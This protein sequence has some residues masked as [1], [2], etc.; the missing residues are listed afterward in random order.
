MLLFHSIYVGSI[1]S[2]VKYY[3]TRRLTKTQRES[4]SISEELHD[5]I[6]GLSLGD[7]YI[8]KQATNARLM[9]EQGS[10]HEAYILNLYN[11]FK[12][13]CS[14]APKSSARKPDF[15][16][17][18]VYTRITFQTY[19]LPCLNYYHDIFYVDKVKRIP[20]NIGELLT[21]RSLAYWAMDDGAKKNNSF[22]FCTHSYSLS[23]VELLIKVL[24]QNFNLDCTYHKSKDQYAIYIKSNSIDIFRALVSPYF[25][26]SMMYKLTY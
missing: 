22:I 19:A 21:A 6:I 7:L 1:L 17:G 4:F 12:D 14:S 9:F 15:R 16:T 3:S 10:V 11:I 5:I 18:K 13:Y 2:S 20:L 23:E 24:K 26:E 25:H 8:N